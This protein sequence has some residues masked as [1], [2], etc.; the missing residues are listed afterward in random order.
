MP[1][2]AGCSL[3]LPGQGGTG[4]RVGFSSRHG[5]G[6][7]VLRWVFPFPFFRQADAK[8]RR[9]SMA[10]AQGPHLSFRTLRQPSPHPPFRPPSLL[11]PPP[12]LPFPA[13]ARSLADWNY[14]P[15]GER[16]QIQYF[17]GENGGWE[18][19]LRP[20]LS[21]SLI[22]PLAKR[23]SQTKENNGSLVRS[24]FWTLFMVW[25]GSIVSKC[26]Q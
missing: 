23:D 6:E 17:A 10:K 13:L 15:N 20:S 1:S 2:R 25:K 18:M 14:G 5:P 22:K 16:F 11:L 4:P 12:Y 24:F 9:A 8:A 19:E 3:V 21:K 26:Y 7:R